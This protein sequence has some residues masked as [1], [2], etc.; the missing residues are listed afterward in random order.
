MFEAMGKYNEELVKAGIMLASDGLKPSKF[1]KRVQRSEPRWADTPL[2]SS[3]GLFAHLINHHL[4]PMP[5]R[6]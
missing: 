6:A 3:I 1:G 2:V 4:P 5:E